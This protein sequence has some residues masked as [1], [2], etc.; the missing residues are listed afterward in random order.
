V[1]AVAQ[2]PRGALYSGINVHGSA[3]W[4][5]YLVSLRW[6]GG[7]AA[8]AILDDLPTMGYGALIVRF[9]VVIL[10]GMGSIPGAMLRGSA[11]RP[12]NALFETFV[13]VSWTPLW[14]GTSNR[15]LF[16]PEGLLGESNSIGIE[17]AIKS[18]DR[19]WWQE[20]TQRHGPKG[21]RGRGLSRPFMRM[22]AGGIGRLL[23][24]HLPTR[25]VTLA[26]YTCAFACSR[27]AKHHPCGVGEVP[28]GSVCFSALES[29]GEP[30][31]RKAW[32]ILAVAV[33][34]ALVFA[35]V[36]AA[37]IGVITLRLTGA[38]FRSSLG[39][40]RRCHGSAAN[41]G[42]H[43]GGPLGLFGF[44]RS[45]SDPATW[46]S[47]AYFFVTA[48]ILLGVDPIPRGGSRSPSARPWIVCANPHLARAVGV[49]VA[50]IRQ[51]ASC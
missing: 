28:L 41:P 2:N 51:K 11:D 14:V 13:S 19:R 49:D 31:D 25:R 39:I 45:R 47:Q 50:R 4:L 33:V 40:D 35:A 30:S 15:P 10:G 34:A 8:G 9:T 3:R 18:S 38:Y 5:S 22:P 46:Q 42:S 21:Y 20:A 32:A 36:C 44:H 12:C 48:A 17:M 23:A 27:S 43:H 26:G 7:G 16:P 37:I 29:Y 24:S 1:I 6:L